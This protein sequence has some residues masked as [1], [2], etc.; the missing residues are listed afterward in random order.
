MKFWEMESFFR[1][2][3]ELLERVLRKPQWSDYLGRHRAFTYHV[4]NQHRE[5]LDE[6]IPDEL[7]REL[8]QECKSRFV[9]GNDHLRLATSESDTLSALETYNR[10]GGTAME[11][12]L[13]KGSFPLRPM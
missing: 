9:V 2:E 13:E 11:D 1:G 5:I 10:F 6:S 12:V 7:A 3:K 8:M 4:Q